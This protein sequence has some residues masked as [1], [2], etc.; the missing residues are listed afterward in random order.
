MLVLFR[1]SI[2]RAVV[3]A[4]CGAG[5]GVIAR[6]RAR[7][8]RAHRLRP[9][10]RHA[11]RARDLAPS[12]S[13]RFRASSSH[14]R[15]RLRGEFAAPVVVDRER[16]FRLALRLRR[17]VDASP[18]T[19]R[20]RSAAVAFADAAQR[21]RVGRSILGRV[22]APTSQRAL[23]PAPARCELGGGQQRAGG[24]GLGTQRS[25]Q[26]RLP[27]RAAGGR[28]QSAA[29]PTAPAITHRARSAR[30]AS[31]TKRSIHQLQLFL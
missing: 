23:L 15:P 29:R 8:A 12:R 14:R 26:G 2:R 13:A 10:R 18:C 25:G 24:L 27:A 31:Q 30:S 7:G 16:S 19:L 5:G 3:R 20:S 6:S 17:R 1:A 4:T 28:A 9:T 21:D 22:G 11:A